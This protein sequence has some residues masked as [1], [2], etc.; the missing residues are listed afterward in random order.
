MTEKKCT[1]THMPHHVQQKLCRTRPLYRQ[2][3]RL[4]AVKVYTIN[5]ESQH[6]LICGVPQLQ[7]VEEVKKLICPYGSMKAIQLVTE[8]PSEEFTETY[9]V[10]YA[11]IQSARIAK[12]FIDNKNFF[13]GIL[14]V[15]YV[16]ELETLEET[17]AKLEQRRKDV[18]TQIKRIQQESVNPKVDKFIPREQYHRKKRTPALPL[19]EKRIKHCYP[20]ET[21]SSICK[22]IPQNIDPRPVPEPRLPINWE[23]DHNSSTVSSSEI[24]PAPY[25][26]TEAVIQAGIQ[27]ANKNPDLNERKWKNYRG[28]HIDNKVKVVRPRLIDTRNIAR[29]NFT[30]KTNMFSNVKKVESGITIKL[31]ERSDSEKKKIVIKNPKYVSPDMR[32]WDVPKHFTVLKYSTEGQTGSNVRVYLLG[33]LLLNY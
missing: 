15:C 25:Q 12:R 29:L 10:H 14:H 6:L 3:K 7:L 28:H 33:S 5:D 17:K 19:T 21:L 27:Q 11:H 4:T 9:H 18:A 8:Y 32:I 2:G 13:G 26:S 23:D 30:E 24:H 22:G 1:V 31:L 16:P 20:G